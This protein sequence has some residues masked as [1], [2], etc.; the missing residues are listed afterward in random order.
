MQILGSRF[1]TLHRLVTSRRRWWNRLMRDILRQ[2]RKQPF[3]FYGA[4]LAIFF[5]LLSCIQT[6]TSVWGLVIAIKTYN[7]QPPSTMG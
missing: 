3:V 5:G 7:A 2:S 1:R 4:L 6:V